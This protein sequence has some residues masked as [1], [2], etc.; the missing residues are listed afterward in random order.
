M[1]AAN[2]LNAFDVGD[3]RAVELVA[4]GEPADDPL[5][6]IGGL[7]PLPMLRQRRRGRRRVVDR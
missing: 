3:A 5:L 4:G 7:A 1:S 2:T 6:P